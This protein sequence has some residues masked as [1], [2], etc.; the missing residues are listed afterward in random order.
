MR[1]WTFTGEDAWTSLLLNGRLIPK[2]QPDDSDIDFQKLYRWMA[3]HKFGEAK[4][5]WAWAFEFPGQQLAGMSGDGVIIE[6]EKPQDEVLLSDFHAWEG[7]MSWSSMGE[8]MD[9]AQKGFEYSETP[10][11]AEE[12]R[13]EFQKDLDNL[14]VIDRKTWIQGV[15]TEL[16]LHEVK[17]VSRYVIHPDKRL[18]AL[19]NFLM[20]RVSDFS[21]KHLEKISMDLY[22]YDSG[23][24]EF[25]ENVNGLIED[26]CENDV[27]SGVEL[28]E[29]FRQ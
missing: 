9:P 12:F 21:P 19:T 22:D 14:F 16:R 2:R 20:N 15:F 25:D 7:V 27:T 17:T 26:W 28:V 18:A 4:L 1:F 23:D 10:E 8:E 11:E 13:Q 29:A 3:S 6:F 5:L 24:S